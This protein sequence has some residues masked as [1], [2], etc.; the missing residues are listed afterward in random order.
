MAPTKITA[1]GQAAADRAEQLADGVEQI[2]GHARAFED[3]P[4]EGEEGNRQQCV[5]LHD[6]E[7]AQ[8]QRLQQRGGSRPSSTP[9]QP[10]KRPQAASEKA[11]E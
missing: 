3:Q 4:H 2:L 10:K 1:I 9:S 11:T 5:V 8:R 7:N 6:A